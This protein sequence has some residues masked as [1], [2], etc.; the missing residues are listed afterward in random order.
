MK[1]QKKKQRPGPNPDE[2]KTAICLS[3]R[4]STNLSKI[5]LYYNIK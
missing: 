2:I 3:K 1:L 5:S 4:K